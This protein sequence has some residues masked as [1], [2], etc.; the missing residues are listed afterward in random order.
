[1]EKISIKSLVNTFTYIGGQSA[2]P[3]CPESQMHVQ[4]QG[5]SD[6]PMKS[7]NAEYRFLVRTARHAAERGQ[8]VV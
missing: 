2:W 1:M 5:G 7:E 6:G 8:S 4:S 3:T